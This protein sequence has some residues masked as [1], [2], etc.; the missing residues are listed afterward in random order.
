[1]MKH[2][3]TREDSQ[4]CKE[5]KVNENRQQV[6]KICMQKLEETPLNKADMV[7]FTLRLKEICSLFD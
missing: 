1:M 7:K 2:D 3:D 4:F 5:D 6:N